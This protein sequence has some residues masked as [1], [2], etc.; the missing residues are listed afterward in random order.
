[1]DV[2]VE[3]IEKLVRS[4]MTKFQNNEF[5]CEQVSE[6]FLLYGSVLRYLFEIAIYKDEDGH[7]I[8]PPG[9][10]DIAF[11]HLRAY[12]PKLATNTTTQKVYISN[13]SHFRAFLDVDLMNFF[14]I[15]EMG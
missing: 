14:K 11:D 2:V 1:M 13:F 7:I 8:V 3:S 10:I 12:S 15:S 6:D 9:D 5:F 4:M